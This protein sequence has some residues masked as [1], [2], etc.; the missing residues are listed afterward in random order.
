M[1]KYT[2]GIDFGTLSARAVLVDVRDGQVHTQSEFFYP[3]GVMEASLPDGTPLGLDWALQHPRDYLDSL[4]S[5]IPDL[6]ISGGIHPE[7]VIGIGTDVTASTV[8]PIRAD[9][10]PLCFLK[11]YERHPHAYARLWKHQ[12]AQDKA[13]QI[14]ALAA[15]RKESWLQDYGGKVSATWLLP[16]VWELLEQDPG[17]YAAMDH[18]IEASDWIVL[19]LCGVLTRNECAAGYKSLYSSRNG[20]P[21]KDFLKSLDP[22]LENLTNEKLSGPVFPTGSRAG[23][24]TR[25]MAAML[26]LKEGTAVAIGMIDAHASVLGAGITQ[27]GEML[28]ILGTSGCHIMLGKTMRSVPGIC[29]VVENG[30]MTGFTAYE[31]GQVCYGE[32]FAWLAEHFIPPD[33]HQEMKAGN[34][35]MHELLSE[36]ASKLRP[37]ESGLLALDWWNGNRSVLVD[38]DLSGLLIG[39]TLGTRAEDVYR[40]LLEAAAFG[41]RRIIDNYRKH[42][43]KIDSMCAMGGISQKNPLAMQIFADVINMPIRVPAT[44]QGSALGSA[45][46]G[47]AAAGIDHGGYDDLPEAVQRMGM[48]ENLLYHPRADCTPIYSLLYQE[49][50]LLH[51]YFGRGGNDVMKRLKTIKKVV[52]AQA[53]AV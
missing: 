19:Q 26:G 37:G 11:E 9:G 14:T 1:P 23:G 45:I 7:D 2:I 50:E 44:S 46:L 42:G 12:A 52:H 27:P 32:H 28:S 4:K 22:G 21:S 8:F 34:L 15:A 53:K 5:L 38:S 41:A 43:V 29:G 30:V 20:Y 33:Y 25:N 51:D 16:K 36:K 13:D 6:L 24:L 47:A 48:R 3:H 17:L 18:Y 35:S 10:T 40:A 31:A 49:Y 39:L